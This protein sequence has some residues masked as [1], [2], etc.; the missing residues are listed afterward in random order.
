MLK[1]VRGKVDISE[2]GNGKTWTFKCCRGETGTAW[3]VKMMKGDCCKNLKY[4]FEFL[5]WPG[6]W[7]DRNYDMWMFETWKYEFLKYEIGKAEIW[8]FEKCLL[9]GCKY[10]ASGS[11]GMVWAVTWNRWALTSS[12]SAAGER[13]LWKRQQLDAGRQLLNKMCESCEG[14]DRQSFKLLGKV[15]GFQI[16]SKVLIYV[17]GVK[18]YDDRKN[19]PYCKN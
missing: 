2:I 14:Q 13:M 18:E 1:W 9:N 5:K 4:V 6:W 7:T 12:K 19:C 15:Q 3:N 17:E 11:C 10:A 8:D 16:L